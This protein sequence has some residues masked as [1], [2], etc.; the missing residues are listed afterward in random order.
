MNDSNAPPGKSTPSNPPP[1]LPSKPPPPL[2][3]QASEARED[4]DV[5][6]TAPLTAAPTVTTTAIPPRP[7][8]GTAVKLPHAPPPTPA[9]PAI[10]PNAP[11]APP[12]QQQQ[13]QQQQQ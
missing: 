3:P 11:N 13:Q 9:P 4:L 8:P 1:R 2:P 6:E 7:A 5:V 12:P 10:A